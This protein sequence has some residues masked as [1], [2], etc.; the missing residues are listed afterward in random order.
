MPRSKHYQKKLSNINDYV[1]ELQNC[2]KEVI[3]CEQCSTKGDITSVVFM[4]TALIK[5]CKVLLDTKHH[6]IQDHLCSPCEFCGKAEGSPMP[7]KRVAQ[8]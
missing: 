3:E 1:E 2:L 4:N 7:Y 6:E 5:K 8:A